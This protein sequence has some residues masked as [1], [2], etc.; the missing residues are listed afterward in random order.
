[1]PET[2]TQLDVIQSRVVDMLR[3]LQTARH[4]GEMMYMVGILAGRILIDARQPRWAQMKRR[5]TPAEYDQIL[6]TAQ[7][8]GNDLFKDRNKRAAFALDVVVTSIVAS[9]FDDQKL[10]VGVELIDETI[11]TAVTNWRKSNA[12]AA[13]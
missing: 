10:A 2:I 13:N 11:E 4:D 8:Q 5:L 9:R 12:P 6:L 3:V 1:V 7:I